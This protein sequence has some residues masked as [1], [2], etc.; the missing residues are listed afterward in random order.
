MVAI[1]TAAFDPQPQHMVLE[2][3]TGSGY[4]T[5]IL[6]ELVQQVI[7]VERVAQLAGAARQ[8]LT[9]LGYGGLV[10]TRA[11]TSEL[12]CPEEA[13][14][15]GIIVTAAAPKIPVGLL[16]Q[17]AL[18]GRLII[19]VGAAQDQNLFPIINAPTGWT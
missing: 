16:R 15:D 17:L 7:T 14:F 3:G 2:I 6:A 11:A 1:M 19:P 10:T 9:A 12:G 18:G 13:P 8:A 5:A 4:Q